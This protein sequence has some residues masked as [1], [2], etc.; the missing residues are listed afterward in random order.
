MVK[1]SAARVR[2]KRRESVKHA[3]RTAIR[4]GAP[5]LYIEWH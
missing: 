2:E 3:G 5:L 1:I 4:A